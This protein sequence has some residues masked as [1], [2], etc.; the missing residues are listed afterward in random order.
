MDLNKASP[1]DSFPLPHIDI[2][3][4]A[5]VGHKMLSFMHAFFGYNQIVM[6][7]GDQENTSFI[8]EQGL[9]CYKVMPFGLKNAGATYQCLVNKMF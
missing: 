4:Y 7:L 8:T 5:T 3:V 9:L 6:H 1:K 2:L